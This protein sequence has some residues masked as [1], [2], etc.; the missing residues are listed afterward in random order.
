MKGINKLSSLLVGSIMLLAA[1]TPALALPAI[2]M[3]PRIHFDGLSNSLA[4]STNWSG[5]AVTASTSAVTKVQA[6]WIVPTVKGTSTAYSSFWVGIDGFNSGTVEQ[7]GTDSD[8]SGG[9]AVYYAWFEFYPS[10]MYQISSLGVLPGDVMSAS[11][12]YSGTSRGFFGRTNSVFT[13]TIT[14][15]RTAKS[16]TTTGTVSNAARSSAEWIA[17]APSSSRGVLPL[18]NF[19][20]ATFGKDYTNV[21]GTCFATVSGVTGQI[22]SFGT[23]VQQITMV[24]NSGVTKAAPSALSGDGTSF[25]VAWASSGP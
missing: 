2:S 14:D 22:S 13:V 7:I 11:V 17:E 8:I 16:Y 23:A 1:L 24:T 15:G 25:S 10:P 4:Y 3:A 18:S 12:T 21:A 20:T 6:S 5:Y 9:K 19:G